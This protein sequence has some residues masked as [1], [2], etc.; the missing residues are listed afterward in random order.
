MVLDKF[1]QFADNRGLNTAV[2]T[3]VVG[4]VVDTTSTKADIGTGEPVYFV[5]QVSTDVTSAGAAT[6]S[7]TL[8]SSISVSLVHT[9]N[10]VHVATKTYS[11][12]ELKAGN[13]LFAGPIP[14][15]VVRRYLG[16]R[17]TVA[18][19]ALTGGRISAFLTHDISAYT[20][21]PDAVN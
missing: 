10:L 2:G 1:V 19:A 21:Y 4:D 16:V 3:N 9:T 14:S 6:V 15:G 8:E 18:A 17:S 20:A 12:D 11:P 7:F 13:V 5:L